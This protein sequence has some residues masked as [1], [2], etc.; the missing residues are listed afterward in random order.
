MSRCVSTPA[1]TISKSSA[2][3]SGTLKPTL[4]SQMSAC[5]E[6]QFRSP[7]GTSFQLA[8]GTLWPSGLGLRRCCRPLGGRTQFFASKVDHVTDLVQLVGQAAIPQEEPGRVPQGLPAFQAVGHCLARVYR[9]PRASGSNRAGSRPSGEGRQLPVWLAV[10]VGI[11]QR[12]AELT[13][14]L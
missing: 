3:P 11:P 8:Q 4:S 6:I 14:R 2:C 9:S 12:A 7:V 13:A 5:P 10:A 1:F